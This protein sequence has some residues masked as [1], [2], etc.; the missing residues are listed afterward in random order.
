M[1]LANFSDLKTAIADWMHR[2]DLASTAPDFIRLFEAQANKQNIFKTRLNYTTGTLTTAAGT[3]TVALPSDYRQARAVVL[4]SSPRQVLNFLSPDAAV[5]KYP[6]SASGEPKGF[7]V[8]GANLRL[9][10]TPDAAYS[11]TLFY[12]Q[13]ITALS[14]SNTTNWLLTN[15]PDVYLFG[16]LIKAQAYLGSDPRVAQWISLYQEAVS[17]LDTSDNQEQ[18]GG[19]PLQIQ[20]ENYA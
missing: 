17:L 19:Q 16:S 20:P 1:A 6:S 11:I 14:D 13:S 7:T 9:Y 18:Y 2:A 10:P 4:E 15:H 3:A 12:Y 8:E 5:R